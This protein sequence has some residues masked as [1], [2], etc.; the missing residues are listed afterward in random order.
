M[1]EAQRWRAP[2][3]AAH[4]IADATI[5]GFAATVLASDVLEATVVDG[6]GMVISS[7]RHRGVELL[8]PRGGVA[9]YAASGSTT[10]IPFLHP[11]A[12]RLA[13]TRYTVGGRSVDLP[14]DASVVHRDDHGLPLHG[15]VPG[16][17]QWTVEEANAD[18]HGAGVGL[19]LDFSPHAALL[20]AFPFPHVVRVHVGVRDATL[21]VTTTLAPSGDVAVPVS[22]GF[23]PYFRLPDA[24]RETWML[25]LPVGRQ[26]VLDDRQLPTGE[27]RP[28]RIPTAPL[29]ERT[30]DDGFTDLPSRARFTIAGGGRT[31]GVTFVEGYP[32]T[33]VFA[34]A[35]TGFVC[36]EPMTAPAN[37]L[38]AGGETL[39]LVRPGETFRAVFAVDVA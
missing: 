14:S 33:Q 26:L 28:V 9:K 15:L 12:N 5:D 25:G 35:G 27:S 1:C 7:L 29:G 18:P 2:G 37:A 13:G 21:T 23:H 4:R 36:I 31:I 38:I 32:F 6:A 24:R 20:A 19:R 22:F 34:P 8:D 10:G 39:R 30:F 11:W 3:I 17:S 16:R